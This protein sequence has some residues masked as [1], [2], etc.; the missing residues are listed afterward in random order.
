MDEQPTEEQEADFEEE[1]PEENFG[2]SGI[3]ER[4]VSNQ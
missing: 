2:I 1:I 3:T 4:P